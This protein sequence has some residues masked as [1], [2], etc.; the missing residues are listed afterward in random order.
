MPRFPGSLSRHLSALG[1][2]LLGSG[3]A[4][5]AATPVPP[6]AALPPGAQIESSA[7][8]PSSAS[9]A[10]AAAL[11]TTLMPGIGMAPSKP[12]PEP[13]EDESTGPPPPCT[14]DED[15]W[16]KTCCPAKA[17]EEC[18]HGL[19]ARRCAI[20]DVSCAKSPIHYTC[21]CDAGA[22]KGRLAPP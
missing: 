10:A 15:C 12:S 3:L 2:V 21:I 8:P 1:L 18:V 14:K 13:E 4:C 6:P 22:C 9:V 11:P 17:P 7:R 5:A 19:K 20:V 16:S